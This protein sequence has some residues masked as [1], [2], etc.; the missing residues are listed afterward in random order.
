MPTLEDLT[1]LLYGDVVLWGAA[2][3]SLSLTVLAIFYVV[4]ILDME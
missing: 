4:R 1:G 2:S 3:L